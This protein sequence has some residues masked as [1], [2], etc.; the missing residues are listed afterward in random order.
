[1]LQDSGIG[2]LKLALAGAVVATVCDANHV[3]T[4]ALS[5]PNPTIGGQPWWV[6][7]GFTLAFLTMG[8]SYLA[9]AH[10]SAQQV[11]VGQSTSHGSTTAFV[12]A[13]IL[14]AMVYIA[15]GFGNH[16]PV[17][18]SL[19]FYGTFLIRLAV[20]YEK[21]F[22]LLVAIVLAIGGM[23]AEGTMSKLGLVYYREP[24]IYAVPWWLGAV[25]MHGGFALREGMRFFV[26]EGI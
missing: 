1:M 18:L 6:F 10:Y 19:L 23:F 25:Y 2:L 7:P 16:Y 26:Y 20:T 22:L 24:E 4:G 21:G 15:S 9:M 17:V 5:Y 14:F 11:D 8:V 13:L 3:L 12:E